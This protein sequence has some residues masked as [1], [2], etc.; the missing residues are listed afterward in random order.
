ML[1][2]KFPSLQR[3]LSFQKKAS[4]ETTVSYFWSNP[5]Y[6]DFS[7]FKKVLK[8]IKHRF[9]IS[10]FSF[11]FK[12]IEDF[13]LLW[14]KKCNVE[15]VFWR[16]PLLCSHPAKIRAVTGSI[17]STK[18]VW[19]C[20]ILNVS[21]LW[22]VS[23]T[24]TREPPCYEAHCANLMWGGVRWH[25]WTF[26]LRLGSRRS[27]R[28]QLAASSSLARCSS[29]N[30]V[31]LYATERLTLSVGSNYSPTADSFGTFSG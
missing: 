4:K 21:V 25:R 13:A 28:M 29:D 23:Q 3:L 9:L 30:K 17:S 1:S 7:P 16:C 11:L 2:V 6:F 26:T 31:G 5:Q 22:L 12:L 15:N 24:W 27:E 10:N 19:R 8:G 20:E 14:K 18:K